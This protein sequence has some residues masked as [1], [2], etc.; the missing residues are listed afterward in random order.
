[1]RSSTIRM[2]ITAIGLFVLAARVDSKGTELDASERR[3]MESDAAALMNP[4][5]AED[6]KSRTSAGATGYAIHTI[7]GAPW[8]AVRQNGKLSASEAN[9]RNVYCGADALLSATSLESASYLSND[10]SYIVTKTRLRIVDLIK[11]PPGARAAAPV[12]IVMAGGTVQ[13]GKAVLRIVNVENPGFA[14]GNQ[15]L[16]AVKLAKADDRNGTSYTPVTKLIRVADGKIFPQDGEWFGFREGAPY[17]EVT[18]K[19]RHVVALSP[20]K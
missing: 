19:I 1:M 5:I 15:Y 13:R 9:L 16:M 4:K 7:G 3:V 11:G 12:A 8:Y 18:G 2:T 17:D 20:C 14:P 10:E 6:P